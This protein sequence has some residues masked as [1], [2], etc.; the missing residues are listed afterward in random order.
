MNIKWWYRTKE[1]GSNG[2]R[3]YLDVCRVLKEK[4]AKVT[5]VDG[6]YGLSSKNTTPAMIKGVYDFLD[7]R[8][9]HTN[10]TV[11]F[12]DDVTNISISDDKDFMLPKTDTEFLVY[13]MVLMVQYQQFHKLIPLQ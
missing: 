10:F 2:E 7:S 12:E 13:G 1:E 3:L 5:I 9:C 4:E 11:G 6:R 8:D